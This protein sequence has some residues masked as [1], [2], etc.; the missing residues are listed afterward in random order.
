MDTLR[1]SF[2]VA[3]SAGLQI[4]TTH[5]DMRMATSA[6]FSHAYFLQDASIS[7]MCGCLAIEGNADL[8]G[9]LGQLHCAPGSGRGQMFP[10]CGPTSCAMV[11]IVE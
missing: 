7:A 5:I 10:G 6:A 2:S 8:N 4:H 1:P 11:S 3:P 9:I